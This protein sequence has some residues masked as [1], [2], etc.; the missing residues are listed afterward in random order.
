MK[1]VILAACAAVII[2]SCGLFT[3][4]DPKKARAT[5]NEFLNALY[6]RGNAEEALS[7]TSEA[8]RNAGGA[9]MLASLLERLRRDF[10]KLEGIRAE[11]YLHENKDEIT[12]LY[13]GISEKAF[14]YHRLVLSGNASRGYKVESVSLSEMP[15]KGYRTLKTF[16]N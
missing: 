11:A 2:S 4:Q 7:M 9:A 1:K 6:V 12:M 5:A 16:K 3:Y 8:F 10:V 14:S 15:Y 13:L